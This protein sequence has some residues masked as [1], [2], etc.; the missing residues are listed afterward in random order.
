[1][2]VAVKHGSIS[3]HGNFAEAP[4]LGGHVICFLQLTAV[5]QSSAVAG[6]LL[7][8]A[9]CLAGTQQTDSEAVMSLT[10][11]GSHPPHPFILAV[12]FS[13]CYFFVVWSLFYTLSY[14]F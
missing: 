14:T 10:V 12:R 8:F 4:S 11:F 9:L 1:M 7:C 5:P 2:G 3:A 6:L 13:P